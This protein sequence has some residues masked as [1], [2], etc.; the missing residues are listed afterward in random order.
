MYVYTYKW[1]WNIYLIYT[2]LDWS[3]IS[4]TFTELEYTFLEKWFILWEYDLPFLNV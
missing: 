4:H 2:V 1:V 3:F